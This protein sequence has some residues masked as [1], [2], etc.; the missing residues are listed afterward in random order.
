MTRAAI[1]DEQIYIA[2]AEDAWWLKIAWRMLW[3]WNA[4]NPKWL[5]F[6]NQENLIV[7]KLKLKIQALEEHCWSEVTFATFGHNL[8]WSVTSSW[9]YLK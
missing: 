4:V 1:K 2:E 6:V 7:A 8:I 5:V 3:A 9:K